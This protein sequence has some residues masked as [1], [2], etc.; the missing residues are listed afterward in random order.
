MPILFV[1]D[2][3]IDLVNSVQL[4]GWLLYLC[5]DFTSLLLELIQ[6]KPLAHLLF[7]RQ[8]YDLTSLVQIVN[9]FTALCVP[10][11][12]FPILGLLCSIS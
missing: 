8:E 1:S 11:I 12:F 2:N 10:K 6:W 7:L 9:I 4:V 3:A 5:K